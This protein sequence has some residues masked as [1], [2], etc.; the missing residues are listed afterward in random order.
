MLLVALLILAGLVLVPLT[1]KSGPA[2]ARQVA[3]HRSWN[4]PS[5]QDGAALRAGNAAASRADACPEDE[6]ERLGH[7]RRDYSDAPARYGVAKHV[8]KKHLRLGRIADGET[9]PGKHGRDEAMSDDLRE[10]DDEDALRH[11]LT[12]PASGRVSAKVPVRNGT[13][14]TVTLAGWIDADR[15]GLFERPERALTSV[16]PHDGTGVL[17]W[18]L[19]HRKSGD[20]FVRLRLYGGRTADPQVNCGATAGE[21]E[22]HRARVLAPK[23]AT[24][25]AITSPRNGAITRDS[26]PEVSGTGAAGDTVTVRVTGEGGSESYSTRVGESGTWRLEIGSPLPDGRYRLTPS[27]PG[28]SGE[29]LSGNPVDITVDTVAP[30]APSITSPPDGAVIRDATPVLSGRAD[31]QSVVSVLDAG[32]RR[33]LLTRA[34]ADGAWTGQVSGRLPEGRQTLTPRA[35]DPAGNMSAGRPLILTVDTVA[36]GAPSITSPADGAV[37]RDATPVLSGRAEPQS[38]VT[39]VGPGGQ[40]LLELRAGDDGAWSG[41]VSERLPEGRQSLTPRASD[42]AGN[43]STGQPVNLTV[44]TVAPGAPSITSPADGAVIREA[45]PTLSG[46]AEPQSVVTVVGP[47]GRRLLLTRA[48][49]DGA[50]SGQVSERLPEGRQSLTPRASDAAGNSSTGQPVNLTVDTVAPGVPSITSPAD[51]AVIREAT[52]TLSGRAEPQSVVTVVGPGGQKLLE[53]RAGDDGAWSGRVSERLPEG[54]QSLT[55]RASDAAGNSSTGL[56]VNLTVDTV[57]PGA[58]SITS[59]ADGA[60]IREATPTLSGRAEPQSVV[61][62]VGPGG[63]RLLLTRA[64]ADGAWSGQ[65]SERLPEGRQSLTPRASDAAGNSS[66]GQPVNLT[67]DTVAPGV[68]SITSPADGAVI[69]EATPT[70]SGRAEPQSVVTVVGPGG[71]KL[72]EVRAGA[73]GAWTGRVSERLP[74]GRQSLTPRASDAAGNASTGQ[75]VNVTVD[76]VAPAAPTLVSPPANATISDPRPLFSGTGEPGSKIVLSAAGMAPCTA[77]VQPDGNWRCTP[78]TEMSP[79]TYT[80]TPRATDPAGN[81]VVGQPQLLTITKATV[82]AARE[83]RARCKS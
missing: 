44:D 54:R 69:R 49:A 79:G 15:D 59:P 16:R 76:T 65:V 11:A 37:I 7:G 41:R 14:R 53:L 72:L 52:P 42:A 33:I 20:T 19:A 36:P 21:V 75:P 48:G 38:V 80:L 22:D 17:A 13:G 70:L 24:R 4:P 26:T 78:C 61:T 25:P 6:E 47:G 31:P 62:V 34:G 40:K 35:M 43:S 30:G 74:E 82:A 60:V 39:V 81:T 83:Y 12:V 58:P 66:T 32:G 28:P 9:G 56:P 64:G 5:R 55:P 23:P 67:V 10:Y 18:N 29:P 2:T 3:S 77:T 45:T 63:R 50:W 1:S 68:P 73:D 8:I 51:G 57:A 71:Q 27:V 46:R